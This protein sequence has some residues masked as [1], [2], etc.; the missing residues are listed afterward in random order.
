[1]SSS[2]GMSSCADS[3]VDIRGG[4]AVDIAKADDESHDDAPLVC[5]FD[6]GRCQSNR[7]GDARAVVGV[8]GR[9][10]RTKDSQ[11]TA[12]SHHSLDPGRGQVDAKVRETG[13][14]TAD[15]DDV[16][17]DPDTNHDHVDQGSV[18]SSVRIEAH[19][20]RDQTGEH[21][22]GDAGRGRRSETR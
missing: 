15:Q 17:S 3:Q 11:R 9:L 10:I 7:V 1:V 14:T 6:A 4:G 8:A 19:P 13:E 21:I 16:A 18:A 12:H 2:H 20:H 22:D 5:A